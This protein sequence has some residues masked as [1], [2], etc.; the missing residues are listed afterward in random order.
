MDNRNGYRLV[1]CCCRTHFVRLYYSWI[2]VR[3]NVT[4]KKIAKSRS[5]GAQQKYGH[6]DENVLMKP[7]YMHIAHIPTSSWGKHQ[8]NE[9]SDLCSNF[10]ETR[11]SSADMYAPVLQTQAQPNIV[12]TYTFKLSQKWRMQAISDPIAKAA[13]FSFRF[14]N[15][16]RN[17]ISA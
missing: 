1:L 14:G 2:F 15:S 8:I 13:F 3:Q 7:K 4:T 11:S 17:R 6:I 12:T 9:I 5:I 10:S 16:E